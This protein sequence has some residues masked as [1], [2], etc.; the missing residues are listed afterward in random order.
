MIEPRSARLSRTISED[1]KM[2][3]I[4][5]NVSD[6]YFQS[7]STSC[8]YA[9]FC[10]LYDWQG[11][12]TSAIRERIEKAGLDYKDYWNNGLPEEK[13]N[14]VRWCLGL[15][16]FRRAY[17]SQLACDLDYFGKVLKDYGPFWCA[18][19]VPSEHVVVVCGVDV[20]KGTIRILNPWSDGEGAAQSKK[21]TRYE[22]QRRL[23]AKDVR[24]AAQMWP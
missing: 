6:A 23:G 13:Y 19:S 9:A 8:W 12:P 5:H 11:K 24:A 15:S 16:G 4:D 7:S 21:W 10:M 14:D 20:E 1:P 22:F 2:P 17:F 18:L 3:S